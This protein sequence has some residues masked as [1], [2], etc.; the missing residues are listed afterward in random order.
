M[1]LVKNDRAIW[2]SFSLESDEGKGVCGNFITIFD[3]LESLG[4]S[5]AVWRENEP[6]ID[7]EDEENGM[8]G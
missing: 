8:A 3:E 5:L 7:V 6:I 4:H 1:G 2:T